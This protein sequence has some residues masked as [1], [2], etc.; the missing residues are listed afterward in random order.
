MSD[1]VIQ[2]QIDYYRA[3]ASEYDDW[4]Y[5]LNRYDHGEALNQKW[6]DEAK[7]AAQALYALGGVNRALDLA[8]CT[9]IWKALLAEIESHVSS[10]DAS[11]EMLAIN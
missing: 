11:E 6:F 8:A 3:R 7:L 9:G 10:I 2:Q 1:D 4:F 5:R